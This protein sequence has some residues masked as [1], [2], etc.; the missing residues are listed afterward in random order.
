MKIDNDI[1]QQIFNS[2]FKPFSWDHIRI[3]AN[4]KSLTNVFYSSSD[5]SSYYY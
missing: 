5:R 1:R 4:N 2:K 3:I